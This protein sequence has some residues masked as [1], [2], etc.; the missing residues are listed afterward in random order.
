MSNT[1]YQFDL[2]LSGLSCGKCV[3]KLNDAISQLDTNVVVTINEDK[4]VGTFSTKLPQAAVIAEIKH[5]GFSAQ[6]AGQPHQH[7]LEVSGISCQGCVSK[8]RQAIQL[9][10]AKAIVEADISAQTLQVNSILTLKKV[11]QLVGEKGY[12]P[13]KKETLKAKSNTDVKLTAQANSMT[14]SETNQLLT[15]Q[16]QGVTCASCVNT[17]QTALDS[18]SNIALADIN[19]A[20]RSAY[21]QTTLPAQEVIEIVRNSGYNATQ[22]TDQDEA[23]EA[24]ITAEK[25]EY[26]QKI[27]HTIL[28]LGLG[29][30][31][32][33]YG[34]LGGSM[35]VTTPMQQLVWGI[36]G[37]ATLAVLWWAGKHYFSGAWRAFKNR[38]ANMDTLVAMGTGTAWLY[39]MV[40]VIA[41]QLFPTNAS[42]LYFEASAMI[43]GLINLGQALELKARGRTSQAIRRLLDLRSKTAVVIRD[44]HKLT[45]PIEQ[46]I[47]DETIYVR[48][49]EK[50][51]VDGM[52]VQGEGVIDESMLTGEP[53]PVIKKAND[54]V[55]SGTINGDSPITIK[56]TRIGSETMLGQIIQM[57]SK[58]QNSKPPISHLA[59]RVSSIFVPTVMIIAV[60][61]ALAWYNFGPQ[62]TV[63]N[64]L[65]T[66]T[67]VLIIAC[68][69]ALGLAT[70]ISTMIGVGKAA[71]AGGLI[72]NGD[73]LQKASDINMVILDKTGTITQGN[74][75]VVNTQFWDEAGKVTQA[76]AS[77]IPL[78]SLIK[79]V[80]ESST[81][82]LAKAVLNYCKEAPTTAL[83]NNIESLTGLG[84]KASIDDQELLI[85]SHK[86]MTQYTISM[87]DT[88]DFTSKWESQ[89]NTVIYVSING[90][91]RAVFGISDPIKQESKHA[92]SLLQ[93]QGIKVVMLTGDNKT[94]AQSVASAVGIDEFYA[95]LMP[96][97]K[98]QWVTRFQ[99]Q[100]NVVAMV[101]DGINDAPAL[102]QADVGFAIGQGTDIAI[103]SADVTLMRSS[104]TGVSHVI[105]ISKA[106]IRNIKQNLWGAFIYNSIGIPIA[107]GILFPFTGLLLSPIIAGAAMS[108]SSI[109][110]VSNANRL[111]LFEPNFKEI[112]DDN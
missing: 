96:Q 32:M 111:R 80:E 39:S 109:T 110:V 56:A 87:D 1:N 97:E 35:S 31:M 46:V 106:T 75:S 70:P 30:P 88:L 83:V 93:Q 107:A 104:L 58:A 28:G 17:I 53:I 66:A 20:N 79:S 2:Q 63:V 57:V 73:A 40:V 36:L 12:L 15:F 10:D 43:I 71:E 8:V 105:D 91:I 47:I 14:N 103:E 41:P 50:I 62:P 81:H 78:L 92:I 64:M 69:C 34:M 108:L 101:G 98:L 37:L 38:N 60:I 68:P 77:I 49:G 19:F 72:R 54:H 84:L 65:I 33:L 85:G 22:I 21:V 74:P 29:V 61:T 55:S 11:K 42:H 99:K 95:E 26:Q 7:H 3:K 6:A 102:A 76:E 67:S 94:T 16:L 23:E 25:Q 27:K 90:R 86:L 45:L 48:A 112:T 52:I 24:R 82:P 13:Q 9:C 18:S 44:G 4:S 89:A 100:G 59:D 5:I 51:P